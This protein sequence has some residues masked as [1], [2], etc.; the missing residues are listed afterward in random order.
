MLYGT[1]PESIGNFKCVASY[2]VFSFTAWNSELE[3]E[4]GTVEIGDGS[5]EVVYRRENFVCTDCGSADVE[6]SAWIDV[7]TGFVSEGD[8][9]VDHYWC[10][11]CEGEEF[12]IQPWSEYQADK[13]AS[14][15]LKAKKK[16]PDSEEAKRE[17]H[18]K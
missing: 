6:E 11:G 8:G 5:F 16:D 3:E 13:L 2:G 12:G 18:G 4:V 15:A 9:P 17:Y 1:G 14:D 10:N 7:N